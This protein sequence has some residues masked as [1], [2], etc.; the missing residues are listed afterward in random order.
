MEEESLL[1]LLAAVEVNSE[2][3]IAQGIVRSARERSLELPGARDFRAVPG[4]GAE[5]VVDGLPVSVGNRALME[6]DLGLQI[7]ANPFL[8]ELGKQGKTVVYAAVDGRL[9]GAVALA[10]LIRD[11]SRQAVQAL[12]QMGVEVAM[13]TGDSRSVAQWVAGELALDT[14]FAEVR[15]EEKASKVKELQAQGK[16]VCW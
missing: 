7:P 3:V 4:K 14:V 11:E 10:D 16:V 6:E 13:L 2:H 15:P 1:R 8:E 12:K 9:A 5:A